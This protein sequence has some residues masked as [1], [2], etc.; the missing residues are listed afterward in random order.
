VPRRLVLLD[1]SFILALEIR[2][3]PL[4]SRAKQI[5]RDLL[6][7]GCV[8]LLHTGILLPIFGKQGFGRYCLNRGNHNL[9][10][11]HH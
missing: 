4:H 1:T 7:E 3:D 8:L 11:T 6:R 5:D 9:G 2:D 10:R